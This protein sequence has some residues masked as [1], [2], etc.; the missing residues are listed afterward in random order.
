MT[1]EA[2][3]RTGEKPGCSEE[4]SIAPTVKYGGPP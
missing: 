2:G 4:D 3:G 1:W